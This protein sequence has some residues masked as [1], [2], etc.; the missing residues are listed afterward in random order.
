[1]SN[2]KSPESGGGAAAGFLVPA[3]GIFLLALAVRAL[4]LFQLR[5]SPLLSVHLGDAE[6]YLQW[7]RRI[8]SGD[9]LGTEVF[10]QSPLYP[11][12]LGVIHALFGEGWPVLATQALLG[13]LACSLLG[14]A[15]WRLFSRSAGIV[16][17]A[18][19][20]ATS[21]PYPVQEL[22]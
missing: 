4:H 15:A 2:R 10:Y 6:S 1:M 19:P 22:G 11:Y 21:S 20:G 17:G 13:S 18:A 14:L 9:W 3:A 12:F 5:A 7:A 16:A 8:A